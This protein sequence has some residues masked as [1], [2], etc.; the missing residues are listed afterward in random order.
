MTLSFNK[1]YF[2][3]TLLLSITEVLIACYAHDRIIRPYGGD[4]LIVIFLYCLVKTFINA[5]VKPVAIA[6]LLF[7][8]LIEVGQYFRL[9]HYLGLDDS[10]MANLIFGNHFS[11]IDMLAY[12]LGTALI[13]RL[14]SSPVASPL[15]R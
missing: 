8:Y 13:F 9:V 1:Y 11:W 10:K 14:Q 5:P 7:S 6:V 4:F 15:T 2:G 12:T 3:F